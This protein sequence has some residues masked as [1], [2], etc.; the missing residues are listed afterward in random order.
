LH[1]W[2]DDPE[3]DAVVRDESVKDTLGLFLERQLWKKARPGE[4]WDDPKK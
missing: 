4:L 1:D 3:P 2:I